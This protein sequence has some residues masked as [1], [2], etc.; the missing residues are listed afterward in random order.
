[1]TAQNVAILVCVSV[2]ASR[3]WPWWAMKEHSSHPRQTINIRSML[4][5]TIVI[6]DLIRGSKNLDS[7]ISSGGFSW[8]A[9]NCSRFFARMF[10]FSVGIWC[11]SWIACPVFTSIVRPSA[12]KITGV[13]L[14]IAARC[15]SSSL[16][17][18]YAANLTYPQKIKFV[19]NSG[20][21]DV[22]YGM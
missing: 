3:Q 4:L 9:L 22:L 1:M 5:S 12:S 18:P 20:L 21:N 2:Y 17:Q 13:A 11:G 19:V 16:S 6:W 14:N 7:E 8:T 15:S 10:A